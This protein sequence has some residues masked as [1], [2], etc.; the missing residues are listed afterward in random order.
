MTDSAQRQVVDPLDPRSALH[1]VEERFRANDLAGARELLQ[2]LLPNVEHDAPLQSRVLS[3]LGVLEFADADPEAAGLFA[4]RALELN[5][6]NAPA[7]E[8]L[9]QL[10][11]ERELRAEALLAEQQQARIQQYRLMSTC[12][13]VRGEPLRRIPLMLH[14]MGRISFGDGVVMGWLTAPGFHTDYIYI[15]AAKPHAHVEI[16][17]RT[18][19]NNGTS[20]RSFGPGIS[21]GSDCLFGW[22]V[23]VVDS[24]MHPMD[25]AQRRSGEPSHGHVRI[26]NNVF[27]GAHS[28]ILKGV[29]I[30]DD[31]VIGAGSVVVKSLPAGVIAAGNP[32]RVI[33]ALDDLP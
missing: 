15:E 28:Q 1:A 11:R 18:F 27:V 3:D 21:V 6:E 20:L 10:T 14:G 24:D 13:R 19:F 32:A 7:L 9:A 2:R 16:G 22:Y 26:G 25:P 29:T 33:R 5:P 23:D 17:D 8:L 31:T 30:G 12:V 4:A